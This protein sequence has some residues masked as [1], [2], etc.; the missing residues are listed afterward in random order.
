[1]GNAT[2]YSEIVDLATNKKLSAYVLSN[3]MKYKKITIIQ[4]PMY[5]PAQLRISDFSG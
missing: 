5:V 2:I 3:T 4:A 1:M